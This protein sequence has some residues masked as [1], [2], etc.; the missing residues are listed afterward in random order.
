MLDYLN[1]SVFILCILLFIT[2]A[3]VRL[4]STTLSIPRSTPVRQSRYLMVTPL[5]LPIISPASAALP[6][7]QVYIDSKIKQIQVL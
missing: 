2:T 7:S 6:V 5:T 4:N 3:A 1:R